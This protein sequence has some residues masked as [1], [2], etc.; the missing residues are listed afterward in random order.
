MSGTAWT[1]AQDDVLKTAWGDPHA[2]AHDVSIATTKSISAVYA[3]AHRL[4]IVFNRT[5]PPRLISDDGTTAVFLVTGEGGRLVKVDS[6]DAVWFAGYPKGWRVHRESSATMYVSTRAEPVQKLHRLLSKAPPLKLVDHRDR[7]GLNNVRSN[8][9]LVNAQQ[10]CFNSGPR[11]HARSDY[12]KVWL[13]RLSGRYTGCVSDGA[14]R[15]WSIGYHNTERSA[16]RAHDALAV[17][18]RA[19]F[20]F[21]NLPDDLMTADDIKSSAS[22]VKAMRFG[23]L[24]VTYPADATADQAAA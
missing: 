19:D 3:R 15:R 18:F 4:G 11:R 16:A 12:K 6:S 9:R 20:A 7:D 2:T 17:Y 21:C 22:L 8:L 13:N 5:V 10:N 24:A 1:K 23:Q 14:G